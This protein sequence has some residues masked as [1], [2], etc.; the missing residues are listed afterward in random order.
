VIVHSGRFTR[1][2]RAA[3]MWPRLPFDV[4]A[5]CAGVRVTLAY[6]PS[7]GA[8]VDLGCEGAAGWRGWSGGARTMYAIT[9][10]AATP[11]YLPGPPEPGRWHVVLGLHRIPLA[12]V[13]YEVR[14]ELGRFDLPG[15]PLGSAGAPVVGPPVPQ[16][17][18]RRELP[19][20]P[21][22]RWLACDLH[23]HT[24][25]S[26]GVLT[27]AELAALAAARGLDVLAVTDHNTT[28]H[29]AELPV[30]SAGYGVHLLAGQEVTTD[31]GHANA[32][33][34][35]PW[36]DFREPADNW[37][38]TVERA[39]GVLSVNHPL[40]ADCGWLRPLATAPALAEVWHSSWLL[41]TWNGPIAW[42]RAAGAGVVP[43]G[44]SDFHVPGAGVELGSPLTWVAVDADAAAAISHP[45][46]TARGA[47]LTSPTVARGAA[48]GSSAVARG[49]GTVGPAVADHAA[50][51]AAVLDGLRAGRTAV[52]VDR[53]GPVLLRL[54]DELVAIG[55]AGALLLAPDGS[56]RRI[57]SDHEALPATP[58]GHALLDPDGA[59]LALSP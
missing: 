24:V 29:F 10:T 48:L 50:V 58:G 51:A 34:P 43:V 36:I 47:T 2:D 18:P 27:V 40:A 1:E 52:S 20:E 41:R 30:A 12:G 7:G 57:G 56:R 49:A 31:L 25:H 5:G 4:P 28:S 22:L 59:T 14:V 17:P 26:D 23:A 6:D 44:G 42:W 33:G 9:P 53:D 37:R 55:A 3:G 35:L 8:V 13:A 46:A 16:R 32:F 19:A 15:V 54:G 11:G 21:G 45:P 39:G 38:A